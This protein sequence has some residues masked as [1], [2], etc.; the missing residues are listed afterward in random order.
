M[1]GQIFIDSLRHVTAAEAA[2]ESGLTRD[3]LS[4]L[5]KARKIPGHRLGNIW[6]LDHKAVRSFV[7]K[8]KVSRA[9]RRAELSRMR[10]K[11]YRALAHKRE[12]KRFQLKSRP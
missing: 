4:K 9:Q 1:S 12:Q 10:V 2:R 5:A 3:Y 8:M 11:E 6:L 7:Q